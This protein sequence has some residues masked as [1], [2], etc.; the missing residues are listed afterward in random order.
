M[1]T[2]ILQQCRSVDH[3]SAA[4]GT[5][6]KKISYFYYDLDST[7]ISY[8]EPFLI[9]KKSGG[10]RQILAPKPQLKNLQKK[11]QDLLED[12]FKPHACAH[13]FISERSICTNAT[14]HTRKKYVFN[15]DLQD[16]FSSI[17]FARI[18]G[19]LI[20][21]PYSIEKSVASV[22]AHLCTVN[23]H[24]PQG[25][26]T[27][28]I[29]SNMICRTLDR[30]L[31]LLAV[32]N[33]A[34]YSRYADDIT[35]SFYSPQE[36][37]SSELVKFE[38]NSGNYFALPG[39]ILSQ[40]IS[41]NKFKINPKKTRLQD[42]FERQIVTGLVVNKKINVRREFVRTTCAMM[43]SIES[44]GLASSQA[45]YEIENPGSQSKVENVILGKILHIKNVASFASPV[46]KRLA[47]RFNRLELSL[48]APLSS[49]NE[50]NFDAKYCN[51]VNRR[52]WV[53]DNND[54]ISQGTGFMIQENF[55]ITC[56]HVADGAKELEV[57]RA[58][59]ETK[60][61]AWVLGTYPQVDVAILKIQNSPGIFEEFHS[62]ETP[63]K[64]NIGDNLHVLGF[65][66]FKSNTKT[67]WINKAK[68]IGHT[69]VHNSNV[70]YIDKELYGGNSGGPVLDEDGAL[71]GI[72]IKGNNDTDKVS[73]IYVDHSAFLDFQHV[74]DCLKLLKEKYS[75]T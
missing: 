23:G 75:T 24:L 21:K 44:F 48:K 56:A 47:R 15:I 22:V 19:L 30:Q 27:S 14:P 64:L 2:P 34:A 13:G 7:K 61:T 45:R 51:W 9:P 32:A 3:L 1:N 26:P 43:H 54:T 17:T 60:Y 4:L 35:F 62:R 72:V 6:Y 36:H 29:I 49:T 73:D 39:E 69:I 68:L 57:Y 70:N 12:L 55:L 42:R 5:N 33:R 40:I 53:I 38:K 31:T 25:A 11:L 58:C 28:P 59:D 20:S 10:T 66:K 74:L 67:V 65:P 41:R 8:Y 18:F 52:C 37:T 71:I 63:R 50:D 16:F 46:Y